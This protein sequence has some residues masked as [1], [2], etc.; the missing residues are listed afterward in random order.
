MALAN[1]I[2]SKVKAGSCY[3]RLTWRSVDSG[4][5]RFSS[6]QLWGQDQNIELE[7]TR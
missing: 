7:A 6:C 5:A 4:A 3:T 1:M 2:R